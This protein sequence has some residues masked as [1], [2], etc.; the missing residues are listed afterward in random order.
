MSAVGQ[1]LRQHKVYVPEDLVPPY[2]EGIRPTSDGT[3]N[4]LFGKK[5]S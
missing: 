5:V 2:A 4:M 3:Q 1:V